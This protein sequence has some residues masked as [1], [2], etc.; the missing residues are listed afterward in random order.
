TNSARDGRF[1]RIKVKLKRTDLKLEYRSGY[2]AARDFAHSTKN[3]REQELQ[4]QL[5]SDLSATDLSAYVASAYFRVADSRYY[6]PLSLIVP[7]YQLAMTKATDRGRA[8]LDVL[9][10]VRDEQRRPVGRI[11]DTVRLSPDAGDDRGKKTVK[12]ECG[13]EV[14]SGKSHRKMVL[15]ENQDGA[16]GSYGP[17]FRRSRRQARRDRSQLG[18]RRHEPPGGVAKK[19]REPAD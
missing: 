13:L 10:I 5:L 11:R 2:Y 3:D 19:R 18:C 15:R 4:D 14:P 8:T 17:T 12:S 16:F 1:R 9:G 7:G 6:V